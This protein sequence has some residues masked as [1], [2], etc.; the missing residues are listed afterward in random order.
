MSF[1]IFIVYVLCTYLRPF[2]IVAPDLAPYRPMLI[3]SL[4]AFAVAGTRAFARKEVACRAVHFGLLSLFVASISLSQVANGYVSGALDAALDFSAAAMLAVLCFLNLTSTRRLHLTCVAMM[5]SLT[6]LAAL[7]VLSFHTGFM[8]DDLV[9]QQNDPSFSDADETFEPQDG[10]APSDDRSGRFLLRVRGVGFLN[11]P[12]DFS[13]ALVAVL[14]L[15]WW[16]Y[17]PGRW[18]RNL[19]VVWGPGVLLTYT[20]YLTQSRGALLGV[21]AIVLLVMQKAIGTLRTMLFAIVVVLGVGA[22]SFGGRQ[23]STKEES[24]AQRI[25]AWEEGLSMLRS[26]PILGVGY[27]NFTDHHYLTA[28]NS[29]VLCFAELGLVGYFAWLGMIVLT[30]KGLNQAVRLAPAEAVERRLAIALRASL[31]AFLACSWFLSR[32]YSPGLFF[33]MSLGVASWFRIWQIHESGT[34]SALTE[35]VY[36]RMSTF[37]MMVLSLFAVY[38]F[39]LVQRITG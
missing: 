36:W 12:N 32:T 4:L 24:A 38:A 16:L 7:G 34:R 27:G 33:L 28:H 23:V 3:L 39:V 26:K 14:P 22:L 19:F 35:P 6:A 29:F 11:D 5:F 18:M 17:V 1:A 8:A 21:I 20:I 13:Q 15:L 2:E 25:E 30:Y 10:V 37:I 31:M 9:L